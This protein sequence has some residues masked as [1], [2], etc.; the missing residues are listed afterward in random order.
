MRGPN[1]IDDVPA[2]KVPL[3]KV[4]IIE[5][6]DVAAV[7]E[8]FAGYWRPLCATAV[9]TGARKGEL[10]GIRRESVNLRLWTLSIESSYT[11]P[12]KSARSRVVPIPPELRPYIEQALATSKTLGSEFLFPTQ[13]GKMATR[14]L[15]LA[16][17][18][19][20]ALV[21]AGIIDHWGLRCRRR[22]CGYVETRREA[23]DDVRCP[24]CRMRLWPKPMPPQAISFKTLRAIFGTVA[25][26]VAGG[27]DFAK[28]VLGH[29]SQ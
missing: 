24:K 5:P 20:R 1:P 2:I 6:D 15:D 22:G 28:V 17:M 16:G 10:I 19:K 7:V 4:V 23:T 14:N 3:P 18:M 26:E 11:G 21:R 12:T 8:S 29:A 9:Y 25:C 27:T 13:K